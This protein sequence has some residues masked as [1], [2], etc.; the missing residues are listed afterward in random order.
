METRRQTAIA[1][2]ESLVREIFG[3]TGSL[4]LQSEEDWNERAFYIEEDL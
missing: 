3:E 2:F 4:L 1:R